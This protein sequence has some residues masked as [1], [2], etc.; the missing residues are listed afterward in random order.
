MF[1]HESHLQTTDIVQIP[2]V[3]HDTVVRDTQERGTRCKQG[4]ALE[5]KHELP[6][7][8]ATIVFLTSFRVQVLNAAF[9]EYVSIRSIL[10]CQ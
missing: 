3:L 7:E 9:S 5:G 6:V 1:V 4:D 8:V 10:I 2:T